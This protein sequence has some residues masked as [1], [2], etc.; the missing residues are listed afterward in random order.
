MKTESK[1]RSRIIRLVLL[2]AVLAASQTIGFET[3][4]K[5]QT[6]NATL[7]S[8]SAFQYI[9]TILMENNGLCDVTPSV[10]SGCSSSS[11]PAPYL[12]S[13]AQTYGF[14][15]HYTAVD[16]PSEPNY[17]ALFGGSTFGY[18]SDGY[19]CFQLNA[20]NL[21]DR[22]E[23]AG[24]TWKAFA[25]DASGSGTCSFT[26]PRTGDHY[27]FIDFSDMKTSAR[28]A[29]M[30][31]TTSPLDPE[32]VAALNGA[33][34]PNYV[35][36]TPT[37]TDNMHSSSVAVGDAY[38]ATLVPLILSSRMFTTQKAAL[39]IV[40]DEGH[41]FCPT[42]NSSSDCI[43]AEWSG[44]AV[45]KAYRSST[46]YNHYSYLSTLEANWNLPSL[47]SNDASAT[48]MTEF[49]GTS[50]PPTLS[51]SFTYSPS[52]PQRGQ[53]V[54]FTGSVSGGSPPY[55]YSWSFGDGSTGMGSSPQHTYSSAGTLTVALT[56]KDNGSPQQ[57]ATSQQSLTVSG[58]P[59][60]L[61][62]SFAYSP[63]STQ[64]GQPVTFTASASG[65]TSPFT[66]SW[67][68]GD[69]ST[70]T[71]SSV[72]HTYSSAGSFTT[73]LTVKDSSSP[74]QTATSQMTV[75]VTS[76]PP[77]ISASFTLSPSSPSAGQP[78]SFTASAS[79][80][81]PP[82]SYTWSYGDG[83]NGTGLQ[84]THAYI[85]D[86]TYQVTLTVAD[87]TVS[88]GTWVAPVVVGTA[89]LQDGFTYS[90]TSPQPGDNINFT[91]S[92]RGGTPPYSYSWDFGNGA[93]ASGASATYSYASAGS[94][95]VT[96]TVIDSMNRSNNAS[97]S[98]TIYSP[99]HPDFTLNTDQS[100]LNAQPGSEQL[101]A[102]TV[103]DSTSR[104]GTIMFNATISPSGPQISL[105]PANVS[106]SAEGSGTTSLDIDFA[107]NT[108]PGPYW[109]QVS[110]TNGSITH[111]IT[112]QV[113]VAQPSQPPTSRQPCQ[114]CLVSAAII[115]I[116]GVAGTVT[117]VTQMRRSRRLAAV[118]I[119]TANEDD[120]NRAS[121][122]LGRPLQ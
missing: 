71:G 7:S 114:F 81:T 10:V 79:G 45:K 83:S 61:T 5:L 80:G 116:L 104:S 35:W 90:P 74:Q 87:S 32:F 54:S 112:V 56:V 121:Q 43:V 4:W 62:A 75:A 25:E 66:F 23:A 65:G 107:P 18:T 89:S 15:T 113:D 122:C 3:S 88:T 50:P 109:I 34:L 38:L 67:S 20:P 13:L 44:P 111:S 39:F 33:T 11:I 47:T 77:P 21:V 53:A 40:F 58:A 103:T 105:T 1:R 101:L 118:R 102:I 12:T 22:L 30:L 92:A 70:G 64:A 14:S 51:A 115:A 84:S 76:P 86:G 46:S 98:L 95:T 8:S 27:P 26:P 49:F 97:Q 99:G 36:L 85:R 93:S 28:C 17:V 120:P 60:P 73:A 42:G 110:A 2:M 68:F 57:T 59:P 48:P 108:T 52:S 72:T 31:T 119:D 6:V 55:S 82:Y 29:N 91:P 9:V 41:D 37:D 63:S 117:L 16:H 100:T 106:L 69:G 24:L 19:C 96:L 78:V 94:Y